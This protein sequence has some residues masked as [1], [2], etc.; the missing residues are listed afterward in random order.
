MKKIISL[1]SD[2]YYESQG[3]E[4]YEAAFVKILNREYYEA[5][6][7]FEEALKFQ[8]LNPEYSFYCGLSAYYLG[9]DSST[10]FKKAA[11][12]DVDNSEYQMWYGIA[13]YAEGEYVLA[14]QALLYAFSLDDQT[15][16]IRVYYV[17]CLNQLRD[18]EASEEFILN[19]QGIEKATSDE[20][21]ELG[22]A[23][24][25]QVKVAEAE[26]VFLKSIERNA[27]NVIVYYFL[28]RLYC[29]EGLFEKAKDSL[30]ALLEICPQEEEMVTKQLKAI[31]SMQSF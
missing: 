22:Y 18:F 8:P 29:R 13:L 3:R 20:L 17:K 25:N 14:K 7:L 9:E 24:W 27:E 5:F 21:F 6:V 30:I 26:E 12:F 31:E 11:A 2:E 28:S 16:K 1:F 15:P 4:N 10:Y 23:Y 19:T